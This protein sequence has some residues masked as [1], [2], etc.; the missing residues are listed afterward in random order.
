MKLTAY[1]TFLATLCVYGPLTAQ[2]L[3]TIDRQAV[4]TRHDPTLTA[5]DYSA[6]LTVGNGGFAF[7]VDI[8]GLQTFGDAYHKGGIPLETLARWCW[9]SEENE[10][11]YTLADASREFTQADGSKILLPAKGST[12]EALWF[13]RNPRLH[14]LGQVAL[15]WEGAPGGRLA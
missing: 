4:V 7:T 12:E 15:E 9:T 6:P 13:R 5:I 10:A 1:F 11:G 3:E 2:S 14:P 8:T